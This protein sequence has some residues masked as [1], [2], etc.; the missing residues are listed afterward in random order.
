MNL[1]RAAAQPSSG[2]RRFRVG[3]L[4]ACLSLTACAGTEEQSGAD[5][6]TGSEQE[7]ITINIGHVLTTDE[8]VHKE[9]VNVAEAV[10]ER[11]DGRLVI[12]VFPNG[13]L[14]Q[15]RDLIEQAVLGEALIVGMDPGY[16]ADVGVSEMGILNGPF[17]FEDETEVIKLTESDLQESWEEQL[18]AESGLVSFSWN[19]YF[20]PRH[21]IGDEGYPT[22]DSLTDVN[23]RILPNPVWIETF[24]ALPGTPVQLEFSEV[25]TGLSQGV[26]DAA[27]MPLS[28]YLASSLY[29][30]ADTVTLTSHFLQTS[31]YGIHE[32]IWN[33]LDAELQTIL[34]EEFHAAGERLTEV[35]VADQETLRGELEALGVTFVEADRDAYTE[36]VQPFY[37]AFPE[38]PDDLYEQVRDAIEE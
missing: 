16:A 20:G 22:P 25:Y 29:E 7:P 35:T 13:E 18:R 38:W 32:S 10:A 3:L 31:G 15:N 4:L 17:L 2:A 26:V 33:S 8:Q 1:H 14:G 11:S 5:G 34:E 24:E 9:L 21:I 28:T 19:W 36:A 6:D 27:E 12:E 37:S 23:I 30:V